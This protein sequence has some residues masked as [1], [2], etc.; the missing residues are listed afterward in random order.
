M[1]LFIKAS[2]PA[3]LAPNEDIRVPETV[4]PKGAAARR[5]AGPAPTTVPEPTVGKVTACGSNTYAVHVMVVS[6]SVTSLS[7]SFAVAARRTL[8]QMR[9]LL[10]KVRGAG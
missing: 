9:T 8:V 10:P 1:D 5:R 4:Q 2:K 7:Q 3:S 6:T